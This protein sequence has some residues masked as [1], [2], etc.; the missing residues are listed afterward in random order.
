MSQG[1]HI[2]SQGGA[3][4][5][6]RISGFVLGGRRR[7]AHARALD[8]ERLSVL[9]GTQLVSGSLNLI[10]RKAVFLRR[11]EAF[12]IVG[13][14]AYWK[15]QINGVPVIVNRWLGCPA[16]VYEVFASVHLRSTLSLDDA[17]EVC[18]TL[19][20]A[21]VDRARTQALGHRLV[22]FAVWRWRE[23][24]FYTGERYLALMRHRFLRRYTG[25]A[26]Q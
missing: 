13:E 12:L 18:L 26:F 9:T 1:D 14:H 10:S 20:L 2:M 24:L 21:Y 17:S 23:R 6:L 22:W 11:E 15:A 8:V 19:P 16:H 4:S 5:E 7:A 3:T 25:W